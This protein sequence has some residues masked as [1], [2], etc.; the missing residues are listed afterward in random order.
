MRKNVKNTLIITS[1]YIIFACQ[2]HAFDID[3]TVDDEIRKNY[4]PT[5]LI[6]DVGLKE[7]ALDKNIQSTPPKG[8]V[9]ENLPALPTITKSTQTTKTSDVK[10]SVVK[11]TYKPYTGGNIKIKSGTSFNVINNSSISDWQKKGTIVKF[12]TKGNKY[13]KQYTIPDGTVFIGEILESHQPQ[14]SCNGGLIVI[15]V[16]TMIYKGQRI[17]VTAYVTRANDK[18]IF[19]NNIKGKRTYLKTMWEKGNWGRSIFNKMMTVSVGLGADSSTLILTPF[20]VA[21]GT[22]CFGLNTIISPITAFF[23]KGEHISIPADSNFRI[24]LIEDVMID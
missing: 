6:Q 3:E 22:L 19:F 11:Q 23:S 21:Y 24:K 4:N 9:D 13:G 20:P 15:K 16:D 17:P 2:G 7:N 10:Q 14:I 8:L 1:L 18:K 12:A 5:Q